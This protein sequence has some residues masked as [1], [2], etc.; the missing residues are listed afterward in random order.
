MYRILTGLNPG[1]IRDELTQLANPTLPRYKAK[2]RE[3]EVATRMTVDLDDTPA[4]MATAAAVTAPRPS[5]SSTT[6]SSGLSRKEY[7]NRDLRGRCIK[8]GDSSHSSRSCDRTGLVCHYCGIKGHTSTVCWRKATGQ[9][10]P[11]TRPADKDNRRKATAA[12]TTHEEA[13]ADSSEEDEPPAYAD[14]DQKQQARPVHRLL[15]ISDS[16]V[17]PTPRLSVTITSRSL[18]LSLIHI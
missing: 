5:T 3:L 11:N 13:A 8:C 7:F 15:H 14:T 18:S 17:S 4:P 16:A 1:K 12:K 6:P 9:P 10:A 2:I